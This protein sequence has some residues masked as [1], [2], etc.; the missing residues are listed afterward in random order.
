MDKKYIYAPESKYLLVECACNNQQ[1]IFGSAA[2][3]VKCSVCGNVLAEPKGG[4]ADVK[5][6]ILK[7]ME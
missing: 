5:A 6:K 3:I 4:K 2:T 7:V 1:T